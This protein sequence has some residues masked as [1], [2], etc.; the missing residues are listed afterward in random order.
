MAFDRKTTLTVVGEQ[1]PAPD[2][3]LRQMLTTLIHDVLEREFSRELG[4]EPFERTVRRTGWRNGYRPRQW[5]TRVGSLALKIPRDRQGRFQPSLFARYQRSEKALVLALQ[6]M[7]VQG[8]STRK[9]SAIV[10]QLCGMTISASEVSALVKKLDV[11]LAAWRSRS[12]DSTTYPILVVDAHHEQVR[13][14]GHVRS[15]AML[16]VIGITADGHREHLGCWLGVSESAESWGHV[17]AQLTQR[18]VRGVQYIV[19]DEHQGLVTTAHRY[20][21]DAVHQRCQVH[22]LRNALAKVSGERRQQ[23]L[24]SALRDVWAAPARVLAEDRLMRLIATLR[25]PLPALAEWLEATA[26]ETLAVYL[27][28]EG[29]L[30]R[31]LRTT[32]SIEHEH[33]E[34]QRRTKVVRIFPNEASLL[35]LGTALAIERNEQWQER[36][37]LDPEDVQRIAEPKPV[38]P[39]TA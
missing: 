8:V 19:S 15:T 38:M 28:P 18:G 31:K 17:F 20:F 22:Y 11:E 36:R 14:D 6:E 27:L 13:R 33:G 30:R 21:P 39:K 1:E 25:K 29:D 34:M 7:Y 26:H 16:W 10:E 32:N 2:D 9:V 5:V 35:R 37:Y 4:A 12:L 3:A 23:Q 24:V